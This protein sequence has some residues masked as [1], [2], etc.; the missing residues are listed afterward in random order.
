MK[1][2]DKVKVKSW[3]YEWIE[4]TLKREN[5]PLYYENHKLNDS[6]KKSYTINIDWTESWWRIRSRTH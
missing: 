3:F 4:G 1:Y 6:L 5:T 2:W